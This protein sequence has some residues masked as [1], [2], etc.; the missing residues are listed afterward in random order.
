MTP[1]T[2]LVNFPAPQFMAVI[3]QLVRAQDC[4]S[5]GRGF[6]SRWPPHC[7]GKPSSDHSD[8]AFCWSICTYNSVFMG[9]ATAFCA[10]S[11]EFWLQVKIPQNT[12]QNTGG[13]TLLFVIQKAPHADRLENP[14]SSP[15]NFEEVIGA[16]REFGATA[17]WTPGIAS[18]RNPG[19]DGGMSTHRESKTHL[20]SDFR[21]QDLPRIYQRACVLSSFRLAPPHSLGSADD[22]TKT[23]NRSAFLRT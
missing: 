20:Q 9:R 3:A 18:R 16:V 4:E 17:L 22:T 11:G 1:K 15:M 10:K 13:L 12:P 19:K 7:F 6:E 21:A 2:R 14:L 5:W 23:R 8:W